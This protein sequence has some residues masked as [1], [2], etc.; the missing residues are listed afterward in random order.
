MVYLKVA[1]IT[2]VILGIQGHVANHPHKGKYLR[3]Y[4]KKWSSSY[5][6]N[7]YI[8]GVNT[9]CGK[10]IKEF[11]H[12]MS[13][14][15]KEAWALTMVDSW[16][17]S[18]DGFAYGVP[19]ILGAYDQCLR[20]ASTN[21]NIRGKYCRIFKNTEPVLENSIDQK[22][23]VQWVGDGLQWSNPEGQSI[24]QPIQW[25]GQ[26]MDQ[27]RK[28]ISFDFLQRDSQQSG[29]NRVSMRKKNYNVNILEDH[30]SNSSVR[31]GGIP[32]I[33]PYGFLIY[34]TCM[35]HVCTKDQL[36]ASVAVSNIQTP[37][38]PWVINCDDP[39]PEISLDAVD[40]SFIC[41]YT[42]LAS[43]LINSNP[44][45]QFVKFR[46]IIKKLLIVFMLHTL[47]LKL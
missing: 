47:G 15:S 11:N 32:F 3:D 29:L 6:P 14:Q 38:T 43:I 12:A 2:A 44:A 27:L 13:I 36:Q 21:N 17:K 22:S 34:G 18:N 30:R 33:H 41:G 8:V 7:R 16:G 24:D 40:I 4:T 37:G 20:I 1:V 25:R 28:E 10:A 46:L 45:M 42:N 35:P 23:P 5:L 31:M 26:S 9:P 39:D 19:Y